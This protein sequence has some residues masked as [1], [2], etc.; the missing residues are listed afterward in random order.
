MQFSYK[1][2]DRDGT[3]TSG[4]IDAGDQNAASA[5]LR[6]KGLYV[7]EIK[8]VSEKKSVSKLFAKKVSL[9]DKII[10]TEQLAIMIKSGLSIVEAL[11]ALGE[12]TQ[13]KL[14]GSQIEKIITLVRGGTPLSKALAEFPDTFSE[15]YCNMIKSGEESGNVDKVLVRLATQIEKDYELK[16]KVKGALVY[17]VF[18]LVAMIAVV[19]LIL[20]FIIPQLKLIFED[21]GVPLPFL[22]R[23]VIAI[24]VFLKSYIFYLLI[25][26]AAVVVALWRY[27]KTE[28]GKRMFDELVLHIPVFGGLYKKTYMARF[29]RTFSAL[30]SAGLPLLD[31]FRVSKQAIG[32]VIY[33]DELEKMAAEIKVGHTIS[34]TLK[35]SSLFPKMV[36]QLATVGEKSGSL[37][38]VFNTLADF[39][40][41]DVDNISANLSMLLEPVLMV[42]LGVGIGLLIVSVLQPIYGL[43]NA[44]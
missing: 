6:E 27:R 29:T 41:R 13:N 36:G 7:T 22:T 2:K 28:S 9:K 25:I 8:K 35:K 40:D 34:E 21:A 43:V 4:I 10:F 1:A 5:S 26:F 19:I 24:S 31:V 14:F 3:G 33:E 11:E 30:V 32:N 44:I 37:D 38:E 18:I 15:V 23:I 17:P 20:T 39:F 42:V 16:R 12:E